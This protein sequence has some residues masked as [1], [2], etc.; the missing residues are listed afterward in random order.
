MT[1]QRAMPRDSTA[2]TL[3]DT[4][5]AEAANHVARRHHGVVRP[6]LPVRRDLDALVQTTFLRRAGR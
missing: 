1:K 4:I 6:E 5:S 3:P 2:I